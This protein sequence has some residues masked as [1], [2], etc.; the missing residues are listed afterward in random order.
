MRLRRFTALSVGVLMGVGLLSAPP[1]ATAGTKKPSAIKSVTAGPGSSP[2]TVVFRWKSAGKRTDYFLLETGL[3]AFSKSKKS[4]LPT[5]GRQARTFKISAR[6]RSWTMSRAQSAGAGAPVGSGNHLYYRLTAVN[7]VGRK[8]YAKAYPYLRTVIAEGTAQRRGRVD[9]YASCHLQSAHRSTGHGQPRLVEQGRL[10]RS[11]HHPHGRR[12]RPVAGDV[13]RTCRRQE[14]RDRR[15]RAAD[16]DLDPA[17]RQARWGGL[18]LRHGAHHLLPELQ[19]AFGHPGR[20]HPLRQQALQAAQFLPG[21]HRRCELQPL[22]LFRA[23]DPDRGQRDE[24]ATRWPTLC[25]KADPTGRGSGRS[26]LISTSDTARTKPR[27]PSTTG[28]GARNPGQS[29]RWR[30]G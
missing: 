5:S 30:T 6:A 18:R 13:A 21:V 23:P 1:S 16:L 4:P 12:S 3:T 29:S 17:S 22:L 26:R 11:G 25:S 27:A 14:R 7:K 24:A 10:R 19:P 28:S 8:T 2:G 20:S 9:Q 15:G